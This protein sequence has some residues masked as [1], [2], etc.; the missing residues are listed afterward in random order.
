MFKFPQS[1]EVNVPIPKG[2]FPRSVHDFL[3]KIVWKNKIQ[4]E[5]CNLNDAGEVIEFAV[6]Y[7][8]L[9]FFKTDESLPLIPLKIA[10][11]F[12]HK[13][14]IPVLWRFYF[15]SGEHYV[16]LAFPRASGGRVPEKLEDCK[17]QYVSAENRALEPAI[18]PTATSICELW[19]LVLCDLAKIN[20]RANEPI[21]NL[22]E[23][24][25]QIRAMQRELSILK[26]KIVAE[27]QFNRRIELSKRRR[28][29][30]A[31]IAQLI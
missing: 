17:Q 25:T 27:K 18:P 31:T 6:I 14:A 20:Y 29:I 30:E 10:C 4:R 7:V 13:N 2:K 24:L 28:Q 9:N 23:R 21:K 3:E 19:K 12:E 11:S 8:F 1:S 5:T 22:R 15:K 26:R 16:D